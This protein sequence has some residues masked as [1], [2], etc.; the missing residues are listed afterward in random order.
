M[1]YSRFFSGKSDVDNCTMFSDR[2][3]INRRNVTGDTHSSYRANR[4]F[5]SIVFE[6]RVI[7]AAMKVL[8]FENQ[9]SMP[10]KHQL[11]SNLQLLQKSQK[12]KCLDELAAKVVDQFVFL[13]SS[14]VND[15]VDSVLT[16]QE[17]DD[18]LQQQKL[19]PE[20][21]FPCRFQGCEK[22]FKYNGKSRRSHELSHE[23]PVQVDD[24]PPSLTP[25]R[26]VSSEKEIKKGD[27]VFNYNCALLTDSFL[28]FNFLDA[29]KEGDRKRI[30]RQYKCIMLY[31]KAD[32]AHSTKYA[33]EC[34]YQSFLVYAMLSPRDSERFTWNRSVNNT[35]KKGGNIP[36]DED[37]EHSNNF[38]KQ[39]I[40]NLGPNVTKKAVLRLSQAE[41]STRS[42]LLNLDASI[43]RMTK[44][45]QHSQGSTASDLDNLVKRAAQFNIFTELE[46]RTYKNFY[47]FK[48]D[49]LE[50]LNGSLLYQ[51]ISKHKKK[52]LLG[53]SELDRL[54]SELSILLL[55]YD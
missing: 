55:T 10:T 27:D 31:C 24:E 32:G 45:G 30:L 47:E 51:W 33:L 50:N 11:P 40:K 2:T 41:C 53:E 52:I 26:P 54:V 7:A 18:V 13:K 25:S 9:S 28:F 14:A 21:R 23:P 19:T 15:I 49:R 44:S 8:G 20:G 42:I 12:L 1:I 29:I 39:A 46:G 3:L 43:K 6:S 4:D 34:L 48:R 35:G 17:K 5:L 16:Q 22:S 36:L 38:T 37:T